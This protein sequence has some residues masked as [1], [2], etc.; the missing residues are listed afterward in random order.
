[1]AFVLNYLNETGVII[2]V[3]RMRQENTEG[4]KTVWWCRGWNYV[5]WRNKGLL[6]K[7]CRWPLDAY[8][9]KQVVK[10]R[11]TNQ[12][13]FYRTTQL[14]FIWQHSLLWGENVLPHYLL[15]YMIYILPLF[16]FSS[17]GQ[18]ECFIILGRIGNTRTNAVINGPWCRGD[19]PDSVGEAIGNGVKCDSLQ[20]SCPF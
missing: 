8:R 12:I 4:E 5:P 20:N 17:R 7:K 10:T 9:D 14:Y 11:E 1:M 16:Y 18:D 19:G 3:C 6:V 13:V 2:K 15:S